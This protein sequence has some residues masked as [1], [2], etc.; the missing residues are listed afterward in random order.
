M[1]KKG[2][3]LILGIV[4]T[5]LFFVFKSQ[6][7]E[8]LFTADGYS[9]EMYNRGLYGTIALVT[10][11]VGW[12]LAAIYY[13]VINSVRFARWWHWL[14][15]MI[16]AVLAVPI[17]S[18]VINNAVFTAND[19]SYSNEMVSFA[20]SNTVWAALMYVVASF[21]LRWWSTNCRH[22]PFPQ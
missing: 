6:L 3:Y 11:A 15:L 20:F 22:T 7:M 18:Y 2:I 17:L 9:D 14:S 5:V 8:A 19:L 12:G 4:V 10:I 21:S 16:I 1:D 13:Y